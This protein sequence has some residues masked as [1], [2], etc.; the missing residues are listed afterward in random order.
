[1]QTGS[2]APPLTRARPAVIPEEWATPR[3]CP[4]PPSRPYGTA[5]PARPRGLRG[6]RGL[7]VGRGRGLLGGDRRGRLLTRTGIAGLRGGQGPAPGRLRGAGAAGLRPGLLRARRRG[8]ARRLGVRL[9]RGAPVGLR[10]GTAASGARPAGTG[11]GVAARPGR[12]TLLAGGVRGHRLPGVVADA[13]TACGRGDRQRGDGCPADAGGQLVHGVAPPGREEGRRNGS[14]VSNSPAPAGD[15]PGH[16]T[17]T[18]PRR[19][20]H[21]PGPPKPPA[22]SAPRNTAPS[23]TSRDASRLAPARKPRPVSA[24][25]RVS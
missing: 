1:M 10:L 25:R 20:A 8:A 14:D 19:P 9:T 24:S 23:P 11:H 21:T 6:R 4:A 17:R 3:P 13:H 7:R 16:N 12:R 18:H 2:G 22:S 5:Q 15:T